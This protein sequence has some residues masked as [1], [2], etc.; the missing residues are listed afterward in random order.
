MTIKIRLMEESDIPRFRAMTERPIWWKHDGRG[1]WIEEDG[2][3][4]AVAYAIRSHIER[5]CGLCSFAT[6]PGWK[7]NLSEILR[8]LRRIG[9]E[10]IAKGFDA[11]WTVVEAGH[12]RN[13]R[14]A[15]HMGF[16]PHGGVI[17]VTG[18]TWRFWQWRHSKDRA[19]TPF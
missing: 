9:P 5:R 10:V 7:K 15:A 4:V 17:L 11:L 18:K 3:V 12:E 6:R 2:E 14:F 19:I 16:I 13:E 8:A 1:I